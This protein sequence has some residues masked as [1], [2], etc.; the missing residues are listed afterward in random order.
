VTYKP[1][2]GATT[3]RKRTPVPAALLS[4]L[5]HSAATGARCEIVLTPEDSPEDVAE[6]RRALVRAGYQHFPQ[7]TIY[8]RFKDDR[9][10]YWVTPK[11]GTK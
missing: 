9:V 11:R 2:D 8:K 6:L 4:Q 3:G 5:Q 7:H 10:T 1:V